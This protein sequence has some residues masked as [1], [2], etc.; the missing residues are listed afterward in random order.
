[1]AR[2]F[3]H[4]KWIHRKNLF[5][6]ALNGQIKRLVPYCGQDHGGMWFCSSFRFCFLFFLR[7]VAFCSRVEDNIIMCL[8]CNLIFVYKG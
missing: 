8:V 7:S 5:L 6:N 2:Q 4:N 3:R 1:M